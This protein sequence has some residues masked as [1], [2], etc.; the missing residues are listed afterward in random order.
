MG[1][2]NWWLKKA[3][4]LSDK[5][6]KKLEHAISDSLKEANLLE[7]IPH[8]LGCDLYFDSAGVNIKE[9]RSQIQ[10][11]LRITESIGQSFWRMA[12]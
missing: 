1:D 11:F 4:N 7:E 10:G 12:W 2:L 6:L 5:I 3:S 9:Y 8:I